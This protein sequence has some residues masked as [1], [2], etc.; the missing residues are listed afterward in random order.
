G[1]ARARHDRAYERNAPLPFQD[2]LVGFAEQARQQLGIRAGAALGIL[3]VAARTALE[4]HLL[5]H[6]TFMASP[7]IGRDYYAYRFE[8]APVSVFEGAWS[9]QPRSTVLYRAYVRYM[10]DGGLARLLEAHPVLA[11][12]LAQSVE[13]WVGA[14]AEFCERF[15]DDFRE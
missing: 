13:Q 1:N 7:T 15:R 9:R 2:I 10:E 4:R 11:R 6:L 14:V 8:H 3:G 5:A 12:L